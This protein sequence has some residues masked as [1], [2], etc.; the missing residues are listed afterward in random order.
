M[1]EKNAYV[2]LGLH[3]SEEI[4]IKILNAYKKK[5]NSQEASEVEDDVN[6]IEVAV[7]SVIASPF[8]VNNNNKMK[9]SGYKGITKCGVDDDKYLAYYVNNEIQTVM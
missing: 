2:F 4:A 7:Y 6:D 9:T 1:N 5:L 3:Q 8:M